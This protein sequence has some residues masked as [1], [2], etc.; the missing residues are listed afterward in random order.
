MSN[1][2]D[3][4]NLVR[5][6]F[7]SLTDLLDFQSHQQMLGKDVRSIYITPRQLGKLIDEV[8]GLSPAKSTGKKLV[9]YWY[10]PTPPYEDITI[11]GIEMKVEE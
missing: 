5:A 6:G 10:S 3:E 8:E 9:D 2:D 4:Y 11:H 1:T 7:F